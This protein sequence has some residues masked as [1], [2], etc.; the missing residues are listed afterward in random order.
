MGKCSNKIK[1]TC[2]GS[3]INAACVDYDEIV[4]EDSSLKDESCLSIEDTT[5]DI[6]EQLG[7]IKTQIDL[8]DLG[9]KCL[10]YVEDEDGKIIVKNALLKMEEEICNLKQALADNA[11]TSL[12]DLKIADCGIDLKCLELDPC[13]NEIITVA[14][15]M[16]AVTNKVCP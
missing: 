5:K 12:C 9:K 1:N 3:R 13:N 2:A 16:Q 6:Y 14:D 15:W 7:A 10:E 4:N 8:S 11:K